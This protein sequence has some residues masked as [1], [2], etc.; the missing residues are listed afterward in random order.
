MI[1]LELVTPAFDRGTPLSERFVSHAL[2]A[3]ACTWAASGCEPLT[4]PE[5]AATPGDA[6]GAVLDVGAELTA[7]I[8]PADPNTP[9]LAIADA[10]ATVEGVPLAVDAPG[11]MANDLDPDGD[12]IVVTSFTPPANGTL[13]RIVTTG[14]FTYEPNPGFTGSDAFTYRVRDDLNN[15]S[16]SVEVTIEVLP[17]P[18]RE[19]LALPDAFATLVDV[20]LAVDAPGLMANDFDPDGDAL[21]VTSFTPPANGTLTRIVTTGAFTY[22]PN[23][24]FAGSDAF[25]YRIRDD[26]NNLSQPVDVT[27]EVLAPGGETPLALPDFY[28]TVA[29]VALAIDAPGLLANDLD[30]NG[31]ALVVTSFTPPANGTLTR[32]VTT[33]AFTYE[34]NPGFTGSDAFTYRIRD[35]LDNVSDP[36]DVTIEVLPDTNRPPLAL[37]DFYATLVDVPLAVDAPGLMAN[38]LDPDGDALVVTSF[39]PPTNG[40]LTRI[41]TT[42]AFTYEPNPGFTGSDAFTYRIRDDLNNLSESVEVAITVTAPDRTPPEIVVSEDPLVLWPPSHRYERIRVVDLVDAVLDEGDPDVTIDDVVIVRVTSDEPDDADGDGDGSTV[43]DVVLGAGCRV[44]DLRAER[45]EAGNGRVYVVELAV[46]DASG[47]VGSAS[48]EVHV[49][50]ERRTPAVRDAPVLV[51]DGTCPP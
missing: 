34:P 32:I 27:I 31:D 16:E 51:V 26:L 7:A 18:N 15:L 14:A 2:V 11:L 5:P 17:D 10:Y 44:A 8:A 6:A 40:T 35:D 42:G 30:P 3:L 9:P 13:T 4:G 19:P 23:P 21:V 47:N 28:S 20:P 48:I 22:E 43:D 37:A 24:G 46:T 25:T 50:V 39:T 49:P 45:Q 12:A 29:E 38:D 1:D 36:V 33:G 41:V